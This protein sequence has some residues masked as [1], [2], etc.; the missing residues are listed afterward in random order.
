MVAVATVIDNIYLIFLNVVP[1]KA[2]K[3]TCQLMFIVLTLKFI[4]LDFVLD[5]KFINIIMWLV[6]I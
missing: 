5:D 2:S 4:N 6:E 3:R 1:F